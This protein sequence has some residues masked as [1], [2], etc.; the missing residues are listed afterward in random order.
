M[1]RSTPK[2]LPY[3]QF[4]TPMKNIVTARLPGDSF[5]YKNL[6]KKVDFLAVKVH[7]L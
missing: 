2:Q 6:I 1:V 5:E 3:T 4:L 7:F